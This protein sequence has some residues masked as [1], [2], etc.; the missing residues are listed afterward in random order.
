MIIHNLYNKLMY[1]FGFFDQHHDVKILKELI[2]KGVRLKPAIVGI[3][4]CPGKF[5]FEYGSVKSLR[6]SECFYDYHGF[7]DDEVFTLISELNY[8]ETLVITAYRKTK[9]I[10]ETLSNLKK[11]KNLHINFQLLEEIPPA[12]TKIESLQFLEITM[13]KLKKIPKEISNLKHLTHLY[14]SENKIESIPDTISE[15]TNLEV[16]QL[17]NNNIKEINKELFN[18]ANLVYIDLSNNKIQNIPRN[19][20]NLINLK[21]ISFCNRTFY[22]KYDSDFNNNSISFIPEEMRF[23]YNLENFLIEGNPILKSVNKDEY[24]QLDTKRKVE[25]LLSYQ[26]NFFLSVKDEIFNKVQYVISEEDATIL[27]ELIEAS[28]KDKSKN[29]EFIKKIDDMNNIYGFG[30]NILDLIRLFSRIF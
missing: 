10:P 7:F 6:I 27:K 8:L 17:Y 26:E 23:L 22:E 30:Q 29:R 13:N 25:Y 12:I 16:L 4:G 11:L 28:K 24:N 2:R 18:I 19:I 9:N 5:E 15:L 21:Q 14:L 1:D 20:N 3:G